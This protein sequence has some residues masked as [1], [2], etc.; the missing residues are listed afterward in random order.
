MF[1][2]KEDTPEFTDINSESYKGLRL[3]KTPS[4][5]YLPS[6]TTILGAKDKP[7]L[8][9][10]RNMLGH[11]KAQKE[12]D[13]C[14]ARGTAVH[15]MCENYLKNQ[16]IEEV[17]SGQPR[18][19]IKLFNQ[20]KLALNNKVSN[21]RAQEIALWDE[22]LGAAG[23]VDLVADYN[24]VPS[25]IDFKTS[26]GNK[27]EDMIE[28]Y[29]LQCTAYA[30]MYYYLYDEVIEDIVIIITVE[31]GIMPL[32]FKKKIDDYVAPFMRQIKSFNQQK[33]HLV[34][35]ANEEL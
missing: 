15:L 23:R 35:K 26:N 27:T 16:T 22:N 9:N 8:D 6:V 20:I 31:K 33:G 2:Y 1:N 4:G 34:E 29:F 3:Y 12:T 19:Y 10:W 7:W 11:D 5:T 25:I 30:L 17:T 24:G 14:A 13:R 32:V 21:I 28:D 18:D